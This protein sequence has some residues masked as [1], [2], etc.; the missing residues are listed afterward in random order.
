MLTAKTLAPKNIFSVYLSILF[1]IFK[2]GSVFIQIFYSVNSINIY[3]VNLI[4]NWTLQS[5]FTGTFQSDCDFAC[6]LHFP[7]RNSHFRYKIILII[8]YYY[9][10]YKSIIEVPKM[11]WL[12]TYFNAFYVFVIPIDN[13]FILIACLP[14]RI[15]RRMTYYKI[16][17]HYY[18]QY[19]QRFA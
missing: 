5:L 18:R 2:F 9:Y 3:S 7:P 15:M 16:Y 6:E 13:I 11:F 1:L 19:Y 12:Y 14:F 17:Y 4:N 8:Y 10:Y